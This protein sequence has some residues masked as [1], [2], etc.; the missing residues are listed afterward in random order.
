MTR[1]P[2]RKI[3][4]RRIKL[5]PKTANLMQVAKILRV[6]RQ[7]VRSWINDGLEA[8]KDTMWV[9]HREDVLRYLRATNRMIG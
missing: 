3:S 7:A 8:T 5:L 9:I 6:D 2:K 4:I 1:Q